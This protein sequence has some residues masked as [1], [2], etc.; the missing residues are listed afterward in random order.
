MQTVCD[1]EINLAFLQN[2]K[3]VD[4]LA[5]KNVYHPDLLD[6]DVYARFRF[7]LKFEHLL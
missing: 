6:V 2:M 3:V 4:L 5:P 1:I 7:L